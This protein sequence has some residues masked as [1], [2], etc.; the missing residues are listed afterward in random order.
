M[1]NILETGGNNMAR[2]Y[3]TAWG[4]NSDRWT[5]PAYAVSDDIES[6][7]A[8]VAAAIARKSQLSVVTLRSDGQGI[9]NGETDSYHYQMTLGRPC[10]G[11]G[12][13]P[14]AEIW[15]AIDA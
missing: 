15:F 8:R 7:S 1:C 5:V 3:F 2:I 4:R 12:W 14:K 13:T 9:T 6:D 11:G 10:P